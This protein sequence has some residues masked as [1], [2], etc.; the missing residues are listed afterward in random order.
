[1]NIAMRLC[2]KDLRHR[3]PCIVFLWL[4]I[5]LR[6]VIDVLLPQHPPLFFLP[7]SIFAFLTNSLCFLI[8]ALAVQ[9]DPIIGD[10]Q[11]WMTRPIS[12]KDLLAGK[13]LF[14]ICAIHVPVF[15]AQLT[16][17][18]GNGFSP[19]HY[20]PMLA[21]RQLS[22]ALILA[23]AA[24]LASLARNVAQLAVLCLAIAG[25]AVV[26]LELSAIKLGPAFMLR[27]PGNWGSVHSILF[28]MNA[29]P[30]LII[31]LLLLK[32]HYLRQVGWRGIATTCILIAAIFF[33]FGDIPWHAAAKYRAW[34]AGILQGQSPVSLT[35]S[36][37]IPHR[38]LGFAY[39]NGIARRAILAIPVQVTGIPKDHTIICERM[40]IAVTAPGRST[41]ESGWIDYERFSSFR[42]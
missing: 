29:I 31:T 13:I 9:N 35:F 30:F 40:K 20:L 1:M 38:Y 6:A 32:L 7:N 2:I 18:L 28:W 22:L 3:W 39:T 24:L 12:C 19:F 26:V 23:V 4:V 25:G 8:A 27:I 17:I 14:L 11:F 34:Q 5:V 21:E 33:C 15:I 37:S 42:K 41:W 16:A 10:R 36:P